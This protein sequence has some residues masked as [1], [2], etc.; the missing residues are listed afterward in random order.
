MTDED[1]LAMTDVSVADTAVYLGWSE[2]NVRS[3]L[4]EGRVPFGVAVKENQRYIYR[5][6]P[7][8]LVKFKHEGLPVVPF[9]TLLR[10]LSGLKEVM[11]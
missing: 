11:A 2:R 8:P 7:E 3:S 4:R 6:L 5:I 1:V 10:A 9:H